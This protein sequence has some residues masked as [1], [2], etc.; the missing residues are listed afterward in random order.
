MPK[1]I[2]D[3]ITGLPISRQRRYQLR[4]RRDRKC[5]RCGQDAVNEGY[6]CE[7]HRQVHNVL[8]R[9]LRR[10]RFDSKGRSHDSESYGFPFS[11]GRLLYDRANGYLESG[12]EKSS[13]AEASEHFRV[14]LVIGFSAVEAYLRSVADQFEVSFNEPAAPIDKRIE[15]LFEEFSTAPLDLD[16]DAWKEFKLALKLRDEIDVSAAERAVESIWSLLNLL[17]AGIYGSR[18]A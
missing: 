11:S 12:R 13:P 6:F 2:S 5:I 18:W 8:T 3:E 14:A 15:Y 16:C 10:K 4:K 9:E 17:H 1:P 7:T